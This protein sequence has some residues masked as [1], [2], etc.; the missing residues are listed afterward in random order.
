MA[1]YGVHPQWAPVTGRLGGE[2]DLDGRSDLCAVGGVLSEMLAGEPP[3]TGLTVE[4]VIHEH[5]TAA[6]PVITS[7]LAS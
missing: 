6:P 4:S 3:F 1:F 7:I 2:R 5:L